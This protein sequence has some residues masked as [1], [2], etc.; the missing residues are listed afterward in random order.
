MF[1][2]EVVI[3]NYSLNSKELKSMINDKR[4]SKDEQRSH[5]AIS[6]LDLIIITRFN[7]FYI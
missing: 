7:F 5:C 6:A 2:S 4:T 1:D 3:K